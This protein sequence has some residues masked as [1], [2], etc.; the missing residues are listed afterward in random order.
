MV[1]LEGLGMGWEELFRYIGL[2]RPWC[3]RFLD[4]LYIPDHRVAA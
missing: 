4:E 2:D 3:G 1:D